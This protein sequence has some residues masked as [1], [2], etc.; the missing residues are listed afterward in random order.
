MTLCRLPYTYIIIV[1]RMCATM[2]H[3][4][5]QK[6]VCLDQAVYKQKKGCYQWETRTNPSNYQFFI[7]QS[8]LH[9][10]VEASHF[11]PIS[12]ELLLSSAGRRPCDWSD[13]LSM[14]GLALTHF[15]GAAAD[16]GHKQTEQTLA[17]WRSSS[18]P[19]AALLAVETSGCVGR[20]RTL[21]RASRQ[22]VPSA[23]LLG[24]V[25]SVS[26]GK[27]LASGVE[28]FF[29]FF[30]TPGRQSQRL[31]DIAGCVSNEFCKL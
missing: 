19:F 22:A 2:L 11:Q 13:H 7:N 27:T 10:S 29:F 5:F 24:R 16:N 15:A 26:R 21:D 28:C 1:V 14:A 12:V 31:E 3:F 4:P 8:T 9:I 20:R 25:D 23:L 18:R 17:K 6:A 30:W